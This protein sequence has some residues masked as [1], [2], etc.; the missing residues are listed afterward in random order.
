MEV[1]VDQSLLRKWYFFP[2][3]RCYC[4]EDRRAGGGGGR[5]CRNSFDKL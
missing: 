3:S 4:G 1:I 2:I 5:G